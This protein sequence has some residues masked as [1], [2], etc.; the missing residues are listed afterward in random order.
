M[1]KFSDHTK[2]KISKYIFL[3]TLLFVFFLPLKKELVT[4]ILIL[5]FLLWLLKGSYFQN[6]K[7]NKKLWFF[8]PIILFYLLHIAGLINTTNQASGQFDLEVKLSLVFF[9]L[10]LVCA[11][12]Y[13]NNRFNKILGVFIVGN[14]IASVI[15]IFVAFYRSVYF[16]DGSFSFNPIAER[17]F[18]GRMISEFNFFYE[19]FSCLNHTSY[20]SMYLAFSIVT[21]NYFIDNNIYFGKPALKKV[22]YMLIPF[23]LLII[24][25]ISSKAGI[26]IVIFLM[27]IITFM[28][29][30][31]KRSWIN[32][33]ML[34]LIII[35]SVIAVKFNTRI[36][37]G[38]SQIK[39]TIS[40]SE[41]NNSKLQ[42]D[43]FLIWEKSMEII[44]DNFV[45]GVGTGDYTDELMKVFKKYNMEEAY[46]HQYNSHNQ[47]LDTFIGL[48]IIGLINLIFLFIYPC[49][50][51][52]R[53]KQY[54]FIYFLL[55][56]NINFMVESMLNRQ[57]GVI[58]YAFF[59][60]LF[61]FVMPEKMLEE[62]T[63]SLNVQS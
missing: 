3:L 9:P 10:V 32:F 45:F 21:L 53:R 4:P 52:I 18:E 48:G 43:R 39:A 6:F 59:F 25:L 46:A 51:A 19:R 24:F 38:V 54:L 50:Y 22:Y 20:F 31:K 29:I 61:A 63:N 14:L 5:W 26:A 17:L 13:T 23:F 33:L 28:R 58:F 57:A 15:C 47:F 62:E 35:F 2:D 56:I 37:T 36:T 7:K 44:K 34:F 12:T 55:I 41:N 42:N 16:I 40:K 27:I 30:I 1:L 49:I 8:V 60:S 11:G